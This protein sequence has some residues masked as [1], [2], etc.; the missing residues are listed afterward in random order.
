MKLIFILITI[1]SNHGGFFLGVQYII[2]SFTGKCSIDIFQETF[3]AIYFEK[4]QD[5]KMFSGAEFFWLDNADTS[6]NGQV[7]FLLKYFITYENNFFKHSN[8]IM[9][10]KLFTQSLILKFL[11]KCYVAFSHQRPN[12]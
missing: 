4:T 5:N 7:C 12:R 1:I 10:A 3:S 6:Y 2:D 8:F 11:N 9:Y